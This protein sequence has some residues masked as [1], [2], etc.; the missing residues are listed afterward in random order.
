MDIATTL[1]RLE[2]FKK[3]TGLAESTISRKVFKDGKRWR[4]LIEKGSCTV[5][6]LQRANAALDQLEEEASEAQS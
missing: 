4:R 5:G 6:L 1:N 2:R 3:K